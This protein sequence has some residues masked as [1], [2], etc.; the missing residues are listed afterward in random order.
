MLCY[1]TF[2]GFIHSIAIS[3]RG[4]ARRRRRDKLYVD[5]PIYASSLPRLCSKFRDE[6]RFVQSLVCAPPC[7]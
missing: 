6:E 7:G 5:G 4:H 1:C 3:S 2:F